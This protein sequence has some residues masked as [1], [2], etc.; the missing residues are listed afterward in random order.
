MTSQCRHHPFD[1]YEIKHKSTK[2]L[3]VYLS[4]IPNLIL[5]EHNS[6]WNFVHKIDTLTA[7]QTNRHADTA[8]KT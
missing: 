3:R 1:F 6:G 8:V 2:G 5:I 7:T 4:G